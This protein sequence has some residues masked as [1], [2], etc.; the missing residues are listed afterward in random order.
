MLS[1]KKRNEQYEDHKP[2][3]YKEEHYLFSFAKNV[4]SYI[5]W[6]HFRMSWTFMATINLFLRKNTVFLK[7]T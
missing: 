2:R 4:C 6:L 5:G 3:V 7:L 1:T